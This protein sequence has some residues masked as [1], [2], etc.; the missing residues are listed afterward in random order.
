MKQAEAIT[1]F[2]EKIRF[3]LKKTAIRQKY[4]AS[5]LHVTP[6]AVCQ[7]I[8]GR[9]MMSQN[10]LQL[11]CRTLALSEE[12]T[13]ELQ[14]LLAKIRV[15]EI[16]V[17]SPFNRYM[18]KRRIEEKL[19]IPGLSRRSGIS[20]VRLR[21]FEEDLNVEFT[22]ADAEKL[23]S[24]YNCT[25]EFLL[26]KLPVSVKRE[27]EY[28]YPVA[29]GCA[30]IE[31]ADS[32]TDYYDLKKIPLLDLNSM[33]QYVAN[34]DLVSFG[35]VSCN[36]EMNYCTER[37]VVAVKV[38]SE[39]MDFPVPGN[40]TLFV[41]DKKKFSDVSKLFLGMDT[42]NNFHILQKFEDRDGFYTCKVSTAPELFS[43]KL[44]WTVGI[45]EMKFEPKIL[46]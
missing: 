18:K 25:P 42:D 23:S 33:K 6:S 24:I 12:E 34:A 38:K 30:G 26:K 1:I 20:V 41:S 14:T 40:F 13:L 29:K 21:S 5:L 9:I 10:Q 39:I 15:G 32:Y 35:Q 3:Y 2:S 4:L 7:M 8:Q 44:L 19:S 17:L 36:E 27:H 16:N 22:C 31:A 11:V 37:Q 43:R 46:V 28:E 45:Y